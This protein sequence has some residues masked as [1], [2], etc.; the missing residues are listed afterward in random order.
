MPCWN[1][2]TLTSG[3]QSLQQG[4]RSPSLSLYI[5]L[6]Q[7][8]GHAYST[9]RAAP[10]LLPGP[11]AQWRWESVQNSTVSNSCRR[12]LTV[13]WQSLVAGRIARWR[14]DENPSCVTISVGRSDLSAGF[15]RP[16]SGRDPNAPQRSGLIC[17]CARETRARSA[18]PWAFMAKCGNQRR[19]RGIVGSVLGCWGDLPRRNY[20]QE[21]RRSTRRS[22]RSDRSRRRPGRDARAIDRGRAGGK[23]SGASRS[24]P[25][26][27]GR[28]HGGRRAARQGGGPR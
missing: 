4:P 17:E 5:L 27:L 16:A 15:V 14:T 20:G 19:Q 23:L 2:R 24:G 28:A 21:T 3:C 11:Y 25:E 22:G 8:L 18:R 13:V 7:S 10:A 9:K 26:C 1:I 6:L 12:A